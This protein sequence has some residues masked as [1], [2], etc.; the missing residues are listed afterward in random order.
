MK[1]YK[2]SYILLIITAII[3]QSF[4]TV[5]AGASSVGA[6]ISKVN[7]S[8]ITQYD[9]DQAI[10]LR[11]AMS[12]MEY[13]SEIAKSIKTQMLN[14]LINQTLKAQEIKKY[15]V[16][17]G[18]DE[19]NSAI[20]R[21]IQANGMT[22]NTLQELLKRSG[23]NFN[24]LVEKVTTDIA[25][26]K[27][28][29]GLYDKS[30]VVSNEQMEAAIARM[31]DSI[32]KQ[33]NLVSEILIAVDNP[34]DNNKAKEL[35]QNIYNQLI[36]GKAVATL[37]QQYSDAPSAAKGGDIGWVK[38]G[39]LPT[40]L[41]AE[42]KKISTGQITLPIKSAD[43]WY[44]LGIR[45][46]RK[47]EKLPEDY[48]M[49]DLRQIFVPVAADKTKDYAE[50][51]SKKIVELTKDINNC[52]EPRSIVRQLPG[53]IFNNMGKKE[54][55]AMSS[56]YKESVEALKPGQHTK[57]ILSNLGFH[58]LILCDRV[59]QKGSD[60]LKTQIRNTLVRQQFYMLS[61]RKLRD[62]RQVASIEFTAAN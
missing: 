39:Q 6:I 16:T 47:A 17:V 24:F 2:I 45:D 19:V 32:G 29:I 28:I 59:T 34:K 57:P 48:E 54:L 21:M 14:D 20:T 58:V 10:K 33:E 4:M 55:Y 9:L 44:I 56:P 41:D 30:M 50:Q 8:I 43:G 38:A 31:K 3:Y 61:R 37:A 11:I 36:N 60:T 1:K 27:L 5:S 35:I 25:W 13:N 51:L 49:V 18:R 53:G 42:L 46:S 40:V 23:V 15:G 52:A 26:E 62:L 12:G 22:F 7:S